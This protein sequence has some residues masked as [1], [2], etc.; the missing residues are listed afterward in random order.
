MKAW[1]KKGE[2]EKIA[3][4]YGK[5]LVRQYFTNPTTGGDE[6]FVLFG[7]RDWSVVLALTEDKKVIVV[8]QYKQ[9]CNKIIDELPAGTADFKEEDP[10]QIMLRELKEETGYEAKQ[11]VPLGHQWIA[12]RSSWTKFHCFLATDCT[13]TGPAKEDPSE[14]IETLLVP[15]TDWI[16]KIQAGEIEEPSAIVTTFL[17]FKHLNIKL[18]LP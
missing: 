5:S 9:G 4:Q 16:K 3:G 8:R 13:L 18:Q 2:P 15:L 11:V 12:S 10:Q 1:T 6:E 17:S 14:Q 7:Q